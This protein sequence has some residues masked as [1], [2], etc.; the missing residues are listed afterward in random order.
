[1]RVKICGVTNAEDGKL[2]LALG[3]DE[4]GFILAPSPRRVAPES[5]KVIVETLRGDSN[6]GAFKA[7]GVFVN[8]EPR[9]MRDIMTFA[10]LDLAQIHGDESPEACAAF[11]FPWYKALRIGSVADAERL[12]GRPWLCG[13]ILVDSAPPA[14]IPSTAAGASYGG[15]GSPIGTWAALAARVRARE[16][17]KEFFV[18]GGI[19]PHNV[20]NFIY[21]FSPDGIDVSSGVEESP[22]RKSKDKLVAL[23]S[24]IKAA[25]REEASDAAR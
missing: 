11:D 3:A 17:G 12:A 21:S 16:S 22:G 19:R 13:R 7:V 8:E 9:A 2:A 5:V 24:A 6:Q 18:A 25:S 1:M 20:A 10:K 15:T 23:F 4:L 14:K